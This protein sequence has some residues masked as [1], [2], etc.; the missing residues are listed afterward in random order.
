MKLS[1]AAFVEGGMIP[2][3]FSCDDVNVS[4]PLAWEGVPVNTKTLALIVDDPDALAGI[5]VHWVMF[6]IP[7][8]IQN[9]SESVP[10][11]KVLA[12]GAIQGINDFRKFGYG[13]PCPPGGTHRYY[14]KLYALD[15]I[16]KLA[17]GSSKRD[18]VNAMSGHILAEAQ[19][20]GKYKRLK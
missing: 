13:G 20:M 15:T 16:L 6:N 19:L 14:F 9:F 1:S 2:S 3:R 17:P 10:H 8:Q 5:W 12:N 18:L 7:P 4:P 11:D